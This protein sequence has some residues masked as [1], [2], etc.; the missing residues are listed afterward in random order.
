MLEEFIGLADGPNTRVLA[1]AKRWGPL[2]I[3]AEHGIPLSHAEGF[4]YY[5]CLAPTVEERPEWRWES[6]AAGRRY[7]G[8]AR[9]C[10]EV[11]AKLRNGE[12]GDAEDWQRIDALLKPGVPE[13]SQL[14]PINSPFPER[15]MSPEETKDPN[16]V[17][18]RQRNALT[19]RAMYWLT[20]L[21]HV[22]LR[23]SW[24][25]R[26]GGP[27]IKL[28]GERS[29]LFGALGLQLLSAM[30]GSGGFVT[31]SGCGAPYA[32][33]RQPIAGRPPLLPG[34]RPAAIRDAQTRFRAEHPDYYKRRR[35][36][37]GRPGGT[38]A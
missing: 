31:C 27:T 28:A 17:V 36:R 2:Q 8:V 16:W 7:A 9:G 26:A 10:L 37:Q 33:R 5:P 3:C 35:D 11:A 34:L 25:E 19:R 12:T 1:F 15:I 32:P 23:L 29:D 21:A 24:D 4:R 18:K 30:S 14:G 13:H 38:A 6:L 22:G 20:E